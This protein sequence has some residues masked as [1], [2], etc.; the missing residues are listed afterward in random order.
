MQLKETHNKEVISFTKKIFD[1]IEVI[2]QLD[3]KFIIT[4][5]KGGNMLIVF[6]QHAVHERVRLEQLLKGKKIVI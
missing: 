6:D 2:G 1:N 5:K 3:K 4:I